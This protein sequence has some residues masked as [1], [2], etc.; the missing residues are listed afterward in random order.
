[1]VAI[2]YF[3]VFNLLSLSLVLSL[4]IG[5]FETEKDANSIQPDIDLEVVGE[6]GE[7]VD[8]GDKKT[9]EEFPSPPTD[10]SNPGVVEEI[11]TEE[12]MGTPS[13]GDNAL[14]KEVAP[15]KPIE[16]EKQHQQQSDPVQHQQQSDPVQKPA[17]TPAEETQKPELHK[18]L[19]P[20]HQE[21]KPQK[22][23]SGED[24]TKKD[25]KSTSTAAETVHH[26]QQNNG[27]TNP[28][29]GW[30]FLYYPPYSA[31]LPFLPL[32]ST[33][34]LYPYGSQTNTGINKSCHYIYFLINSSYAE[35]LVRGYLIIFV[36]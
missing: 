23:S 28:L 34:F 9:D 4:P 2:S 10:G 29:A 7:S 31:S 15:S 21:P 8:N 16:A 27:P 5:D 18:Q 22:E 20:P 14:P 19:T 1:M 24:K 13:V 25:S 36:T 12:S 32:I 26:Q 6:N 3:L 33:N 17:A 30:P 11:P 35:I